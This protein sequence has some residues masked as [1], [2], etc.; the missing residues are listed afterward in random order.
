MGASSSVGLHLSTNA[1]NR[2]IK[3]FGDHATTAGF[4]EMS[5]L[6]ERE[7]IKPVK[8]ESLSNEERVRSLT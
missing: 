1:I 2:G 3:R 4:K 8:L 6:H 7:A 5:Q